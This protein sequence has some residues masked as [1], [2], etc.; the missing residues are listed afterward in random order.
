MRHTQAI[1]AERRAHERRLQ[2]QHRTHREPSAVAQRREHQACFELCAAPRDALD[3]V[4]YQA[5]AQQ[6]YAVR[7]LRAGPA[8][9]R[10]R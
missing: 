5:V 10:T 9:A 8:A 3:G 7:F 1:E 6:K 4:Y 2:A